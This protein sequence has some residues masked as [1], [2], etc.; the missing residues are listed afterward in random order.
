MKHTLNVVFL[1][2]STLLGAQ[3]L[4]LAN[5][6]FS[7]GEFEKAAAV[8]GESWE[9]NTNNDYIFNRYVECLMNLEQFDECEKVIKKQIK[10]TPQASYVY[11]VYGDLFERQ[12]KMEQAKQQ[13][14][15]AIDNLSPDNNAI[16]RL[17]Y[18]FTNNGQ[19]DLALLTYER[20]G[21][22]IKDKTFYA[23]NIGELHRRKGDNTAM[24]KA[25][26][27][28]MDGDPGRLS[29][30]QIY[31]SRYLADEDYE[32]L[33]TELYTRI[34]DNETPELIELLAWSFVQQKD[35]SNALR[36]F[37]ALDTRMSENGQR[38]YKL[39]GD[40]YAARDYTTA[41]AAYD[42]LVVEKGETNPYFYDS[43]RGSLSAQRKK[44][45]DSNTDDKAALNILER[46][47]ESFIR[48]YGFD[49]RTAP[50]VLEM[51]EFEAIYVNNL[52][53]AVQLLDT[54]VNSPGLGKEDQAR[55]KINLADYYVM[56]G[57]RW[58]STLL[59]S[60]VD[61]QMREE[62]LGQEARFKNAKLAYYNGDFQWAQAQ[63]DVLKSSTSKLIAN[64]ALD[65]SVFIMDN[66]NLDTT[67]DAITLYA[68]A[69]LLVFQNR[70][71]EAMARL[72]TLRRNFPEH[73]LQDDIYYLEAQIAEKRREYTNAVALYQKVATNYPEDIRADNALFAMANLY[74][75]R[76]NNRDKAMELFEKIFNDYS[77]SVF[78]VDARKRFRLLRGDKVQ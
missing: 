26:L 42:Y 52:P 33:Q 14:K 3:D 48:S 69:E 38:I 4:N 50:L 54:L 35:F 29:T 5:Q 28:A 15:L 43:K 34:Q 23:L 71:E 64:D 10:R 72:D 37:K 47:Y 8:F 21:E 56:S 75:T 73:S 63:F 58:E 7:N 78:A 16:S 27:D 31:L 61:K 17:A 39:A 49:R 45:T 19:F 53:R 11:A 68:G 77:G 70:F 20:G 22:L 18:Q 1:F 76:L 32:A 66:L 24:I 57:E 67:A 62:V 55:A 44:L 46:D 6:Y 30:V 41:I 59:Y 2:I 9:K 13:Y 40:A 65:L 60:Q 51:A 74:E 12:N 36:Q 25:Y